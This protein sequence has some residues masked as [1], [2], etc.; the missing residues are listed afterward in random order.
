VTGDRAVVVGGGLAGIAAAID[1]ADAGLPVT[2]LE[3]RPWLGGATW[4]FGRRGLTIDNGQ[5]IFLR[6]FTEYRELLNRLDVADR[7]E[8]QDR[9]DLTVLTADGPQQIRRSGWPAPMHLARMLAGY[10]PLSRSERLAVVPAVSAMWLSD[11]SSHGDTT[12]ADWLSRH[13]QGKRARRQ[14]WDLF[15]V[16]VLN[17]ASEQADLGTAAGVIN[18][19][20]L[21]SRDQADLGL[22]TVPLRD[23]HGGPAARMLAQLGVE[24]RLGAQVTGITRGPRG[25]FRVHVGPGRGEHESQLAFGQ[26]EPDVLRASGVVLAVPAWS[27]VPLAPPELAPQVGTWRRLEQSPVVSLHVT[28]DTRVTRLPFALS[29]DTPLRWIVD[30]TASAGLHTG[31]YLAASIPAAVEFVDAP[32]G[33][34][35]E[36]FLPVLERLFPAAATAGVEDFFVTRERSATFRPLPGSAAVRPDQQTRLPG[37]ALAGAWTKTGWPDSMEGA[38]RSGHLAAEYVLRS[39]A[40]DEAAGVSGRPRPR[41]AVAMP[42]KVAVQVSGPEPAPLTGVVN[43]DPAPASATATADASPDGQAAGIAGSDGP[44]AGTATP[45][46]Q[47]AETAALQSP[48]AEIGAPAGPATG[49]AAG[50]DA[51]ASGT[52][53]PGQSEPAESAAVTETSEEP[54]P[55]S[56]QPLAAGLAGPEPEPASGSAEPEPDQPGAGTTADD[57][58]ADTR[59]EPGAASAGRLAAAPGG[60]KPGVPKPGVPKPGAPKPGA[61]SAVVAVSAREPRP[62]RDARK[63]ARKAAMAG[64]DEPMPLAVP[65]TGTEHAN[66]VRP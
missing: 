33:V 42:V 1:L 31:Q 7:A 14:L 6:C 40:R 2:L 58:E 26:C 49:S 4:S 48:A 38:V 29:T 60:P 24:V 34:I 16:P 10:R 51:V 50:D 66:A 45:D 46:N 64:N 3:A 47:A 17:A 19:A 18:A 27:A 15:L 12:V 55:V 62:A 9:L 25:G 36:Q 39:L 61:D 53:V 37:F 28:Y 56:D 35:R 23:L 32:A 22:T 54:A 44:V 30:K 41:A 8:I 65:D 63:Q 5:H 20:L 43:P 13:G 52:E 59:R 11:L 21:S 57:V